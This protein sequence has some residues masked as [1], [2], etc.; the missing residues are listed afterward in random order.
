M[1]ARMLKVLKR[2]IERAIKPGVGMVTMSQDGPV[3]SEDQ[4]SATA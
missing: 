1:S 4:V 3:R 2:N